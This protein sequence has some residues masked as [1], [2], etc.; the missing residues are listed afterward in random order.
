MVDTLNDVPAQPAKTKKSWRER[1]FLARVWIKGHYHQARLWTM[2]HEDFRVTSFQFACFIAGLF[3]I[4]FWSVPVAGV[5][6]AV[7]AIIAAERQ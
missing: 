6:G 1:R 2:A 7:I 5:I 4:S 3:F